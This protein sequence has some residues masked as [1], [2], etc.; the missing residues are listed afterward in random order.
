MDIDM[1]F[2]TWL[3]N[4]RFRLLRI[5]A[6]ETTLRN[7]TTPEQKQIGVAGKLHLSLRL[8]GKTVVVKTV[9]AV[10]KD[11]FGRYLIDIYVDGKCINDEM[12][13][14]GFAIYKEY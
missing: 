3:R 9:K 7:N 11:A 2:D 6:F 13:E 1:G 5:N 14:L 10:K 4:Q 8:Q 12:V